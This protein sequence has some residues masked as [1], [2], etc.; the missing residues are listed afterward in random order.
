[1]KKIER[2]K[3]CVLN[4]YQSISGLNK[5]KELLSLF[6]DDPKLIDHIL[7]LDALLPGYTL[8][9]DEIT[10]EGSRVFVRARCRGKQTGKINDDPP[11]YH[12]VEFPY[13]IGYYIAAGKIKEHWM[14]A[15]Q[16]TILEQLG[17]M[18]NEKN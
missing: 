6:T 14:I 18:E 12:D 16:L 9:I 3:A 7:Y 15:D 8:L 4:F 11:T 13:A 2:N 5:T 17:L 1:M 10:A